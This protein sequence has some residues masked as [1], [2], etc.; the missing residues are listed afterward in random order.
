MHCA[1]K[2]LAILGF[3]SNDFGAQEPGDEVQ[4]KEFCMKNY[5]VEF[6]MFSKIEIVGPNKAQLYDFLTSPETNTSSPGEVEWNFEK[7]LVGRGGEIL[8]RFRSPI[9]PVSREMIS[10]IEAA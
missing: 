10:A 4:I 1:Q 7:F 8:Q 6:S 5:S 3:P 2:G 9:E